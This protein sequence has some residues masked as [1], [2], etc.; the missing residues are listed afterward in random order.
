MYLRSK[1]YLRSQRYENADALKSMKEQIML[2]KVNVVQNLGNLQIFKIF[3][4]SVAIPGFAPL[5]GN[6]VREFPEFLD[7]KRAII[8]GKNRDNRCFGY[9]ILSTVYPNENNPQMAQR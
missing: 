7:L 8:T 9:A 6:G 5:G 4:V 2:R 1:L 3:Y